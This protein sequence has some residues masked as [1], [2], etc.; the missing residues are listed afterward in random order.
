MA[1]R[2]KEMTIKE[3]LDRRIFELTSEM[4]ELKKQ[5]SEARASLNKMIANGDTDSYDVFLFVSKGYYTFGSPY[6]EHIRKIAE[7]ERIYSELS[8]KKDVYS[9]VLSVVMDST[10][11]EIKLGNIERLVSGI[12]Y[13]EPMMSKSSAAPRI[14]P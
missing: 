1:H 5:A 11:K 13:G 2:Q 14:S 6:V 7:N 8:K 4:D 12:V 3:Y 9:L 10:S